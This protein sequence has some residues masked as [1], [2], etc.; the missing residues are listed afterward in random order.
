MSFTKRYMNPPDN[1]PLNEWG[2][3][4]GKEYKDKKWDELTPDEMM[5]DFE[6]K[7][8]ILEGLG[9]EVSSATF[10]QDYLFRELYEGTLEGDYKVMLTEYVPKEKDEEKSKTKIHK[11]DVDDILNYLQ[12]NNVALSPCLFFNNW[13]RKNLM[14]YVSAF[15]LD[16]DKLRPMQLQRFFFLFDE[17][18]LLRPTFI[19]NSGSGVHFY[20]MLDKMLPVD[21]V[22]NEA[23]KLIAT[24]IYT[25]LYDDVILKEKW[26]DA[27][28][29]WIGQDYRVVN[30]MTKLNLVSR[31]FKTGEIYSA[32]WFIEHYDIQI[33]RTKKYASKQMIKYARSIAKDLKLEAPDYSDAHATFEFINQNKDAAYQVREA[34]RQ[35]RAEKQ[36]QKKK[37]AQ[38]QKPGSWYRNTLLHM[39]DHT[40][41]GFRFS[42][43][44]AIAI[45]AFKE[46]IPREVFV[47]DLWELAHYWETY[48]WNGDTFNVKNVKDIERFFD[49]ALKYSDTSSETLEEWLGYSFNRLGVKGRE[50]PLSQ[51]KHLYLA[52]RR[53][54]DL[55]K[56]GEQINEGRPSSEQLVKEWREAHPEGRK[57]DCVRDTGV[58]KPTV[59]K[60]WN[61]Y[62]P[63][64]KHNAEGHI[65][66]SVHP[67]EELNKLIIEELSKE[68]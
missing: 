49:N 43:L 35:R 41:A 24:E 56:I 62:E 1:R 14:N 15:V 34:R 4:I 64:Y 22:N 50:N 26:R 28:R 39:R 8:D 9:E 13:R 42:S 47:S 63:K 65:V 31:I 23:N 55:K 44:K 29:H 10:Y 58:S 16:I 18:R 11:I 2:L 52:R 17:G 45:I 36:Q 51:E 67:S 12:Q 3:P 19:A 33:D 54:E 27:Q 68:D 32:E 57:A 53:K 6:W 60:W 59:Y 61:S 66:V 20:Y 5:M 30:S 37:K 21:S 7:S 46:K 40:Q 38:E 25:R 48:N